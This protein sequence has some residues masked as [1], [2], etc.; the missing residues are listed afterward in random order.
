MDRKM[1]NTAEICCIAINAKLGTVYFEDKACLKTGK[2]FEVGYVFRNHKKELFCKRNSWD[3]PGFY[4]LCNDHEK[5][6][7]ER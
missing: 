6:V 3:E 2:P 4:Y 5:L 7:D 1:W